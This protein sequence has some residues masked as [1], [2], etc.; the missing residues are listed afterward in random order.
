MHRVGELTADVY[1]FASRGRPEAH[2]RCRESIEQS[3]I[4]QDY[5]WREQP[6]GVT[7]KEHW[8]QVHTLASKS[9]A[10]F[11]IVLE[12]DA[13]VNRH[14]VFNALTWP[15]ISDRRF[16]AGWL[17][18]PGGFARD[19]TRWFDGS[20]G[21]LF[22]TVAQLYRR[23]DLPEL[24]RGVHCAMAERRPRLPWDA[25]V[26]WAVQVALERRSAVHFPSL[27]EHPI[28]VPSKMNP[29]Q[30]ALPSARKYRTSNGTFDMDWRRPVKAAPRNALRK[31]REEQDQ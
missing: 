8:V 25:G 1:V 13:I 6:V 16:G 18:N 26:D 15:A 20:P 22:G 29:A 10:D 21:Q 5:R 19:L 30:N 23:T 28:D 2:R 27:A 7:P 4:G 3:D 24:V 31:L 9:P 17:Y 14:I 11:V 12:D